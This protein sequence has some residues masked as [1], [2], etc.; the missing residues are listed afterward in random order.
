MD[1]IFA[2]FIIGSLQTRFVSCSSPLMANDNY[3]V[4]NQLTS[5]NIHVIDND[6]GKQYNSM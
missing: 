4:T 5:I 2:I 3:A 6:Q 1:H